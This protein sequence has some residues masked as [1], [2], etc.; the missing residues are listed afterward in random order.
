MSA[1]PRLLQLASPALPIGGYSYSSGLEAAIESGRVVDSDTAFDWIDDVLSLVLGRFDAPL[2]AAALRACREGD[3]AG[4]EECNR[5]ALAARETPEL[6]LESEQMGY[7][8]IRWVMQVPG[9]EGLRLDPAQPIAAAVA[10]A[11][12]AWRLGIAAPEAVTALLWSFAENQ[13]LVLIKAMPIGQI[14]AQQVLLRLGGRVEVVA[15][16]A[17]LRPPETWSNAAPGLALASMQHETQYS[18]LFRS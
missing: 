13:V 15:A 17:L 4:L 7:S 16:Q 5:L 18:R 14:Q 3:A 1:L 6:R 11:V 8:L 2:V 12:A 9:A 10:W